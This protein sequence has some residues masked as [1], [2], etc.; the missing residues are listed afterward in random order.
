MDENHLATWNRNE[1]DHL[2]NHGKEACQQDDEEKFVPK[3]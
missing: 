3:I 1:E 2:K